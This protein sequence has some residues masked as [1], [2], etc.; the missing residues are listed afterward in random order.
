MPCMFSGK[1]QG[2]TRAALRDWADCKEVNAYLDAAEPLPVLLIVAGIFKVTP[3]LVDAGR[4]G[5]IGGTGRSCAVD[6]AFEVIVP[7]KYDGRTRSR[8]PRSTKRPL[9]SLK[10]RRDGHAAPRPLLSSAVVEAASDDGVR[11]VFS[12]LLIFFHWVV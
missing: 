1:T 8:T 5:C 3:P 9:V 7:Y 10:P 2:L 6:T 12:P 11:S 4:T